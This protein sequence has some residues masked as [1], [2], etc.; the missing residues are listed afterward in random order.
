MLLVTTL[1]RLDRSYGRGNSPSQETNYRT[2][3]RALTVNYLDNHTT[4]VQHETALSYS[5]PSWA[6]QFGHSFPGFQVYSIHCSMTV[7]LVFLRL[8]RPV[9]SLDV[10]VYHSEEH[11]SSMVSLVVSIGAGRGFVIISFKHSLSS[12]PV[13]YNLFMYTKYVVCQYIVCVR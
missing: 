12:V 8:S 10:G 2:I 6:N 13:P 9:H 7:W 1:L 5:L 11:M 4:C 3:Y